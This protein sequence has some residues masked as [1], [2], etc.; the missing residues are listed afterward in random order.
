MLRLSGGM[1]PG[2]I[3]PISAW[4]PRA[5]TQNDGA[6]PSTK[7]GV[8]TV[9]SGRWVPPAKGLLSTNVSPAW[10]P[11]AEPAHLSITVRTLSPMEPRWTGMCGAL[12]IRWPSASN[13]AQEKSSLSLMLTDQAVVFSTSPISSAMAM[14]RL[15]KSSRRMGSGAAS[16][17]GA[18]ALA[19]GARRVSTR[20]AAASTSPCQPGS[21]NVVPALS[22]ITAG[23]AMRQPVGRAARL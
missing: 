19:A 15:A 17:T 5:A 16:E 4:W 23:P 21:T 22:M 14:K 7:T 1:E 20:L 9:T 18:V 6:L 11:R 12:A 13:S 2:V 8:T 3:P 10:I